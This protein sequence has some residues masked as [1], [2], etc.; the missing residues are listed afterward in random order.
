VRELI[1]QDDRGGARERRVEIELAAYDAAIAH[2]QEGQLREAFEQSF[3][4]GPP[5]RLDV[6]H[7]DIG[8]AGQRRARSLEHGIGLADARR[9]AEENAQPPAPRPG[10]LSLHVR[11]QL[12]RVAARSVGHGC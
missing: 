10:L 8:A 11:Q 9:G 2:R 1:D 6:A 5:M 7:D 3:R 12:I 4:L